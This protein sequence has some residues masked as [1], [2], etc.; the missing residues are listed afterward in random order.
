M[1]IRMKKWRKKPIEVEAVQ[2][3]GNNLNEMLEFCESC[4]S[5]ERNNEPVL[6]VTGG[7]HGPDT[8]RI[9]DFVVKGHK[10]RFYP[11]SPEV[12]YE[13]YEEVI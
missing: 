12:F 3:L 8:A 10:G 9:G 6:A 4:F 13:T 11:Q 5:Y 7:E 1:S 2:W